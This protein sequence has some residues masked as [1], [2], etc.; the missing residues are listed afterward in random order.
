MSTKPTKDESQS[1][2]DLL[3]RIEQLPEKDTLPD[4]DFIGSII[5]EL[6]PIP[7]RVLLAVLDFPRPLP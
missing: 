5:T 6:L 3:Q 4:P 1:L 2:S 7:K